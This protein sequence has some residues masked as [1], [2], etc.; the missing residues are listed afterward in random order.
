MKI[1][2]WQVYLPD[3]NYHVFLEVHTDEGVSG[4]GAA[5]FTDRTGTR[6]ARLVETVCGR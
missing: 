3:K 6:S 5:F 2:D 1:T 4:W